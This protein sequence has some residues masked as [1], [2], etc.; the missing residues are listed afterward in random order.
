[1]EGTNMMF[2]PEINQ[3][4]KRKILLTN[5]IKMLTARS[6]LKE[7]NLE[8]NINDLVTQKSKNNIF[9]VKTDHKK[10]E[11]TNKII[12]ILM[13]KKIYMYNKSSLIYQ[14]LTNHKDNHKILVVYDITNKV[15]TNILNTYKSLELFFEYQ[16]M[17]NLVDYCLVPKHELLSEEDGD[18]IL[19]EYNMLPSNMPKI[20]SSDPV[21][22]YYNMPVGGIVR[23]IRPS[24]LSGEAVYYRIIVK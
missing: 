23:I 24:K 19:K 4:T 10:D 3:D 8:K 5:I 17:I 9:E 12:I 14:I 11:Y 22:R 21:I 7:D 20:F 1:M 6:I 18:K 2:S 16:F 15:K 13:D